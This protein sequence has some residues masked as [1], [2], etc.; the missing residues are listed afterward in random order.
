MDT[1]LSCIE[2]TNIMI[3]KSKPFEVDGIN[4]EIP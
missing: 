1:K 2:Q 4:E 3:L